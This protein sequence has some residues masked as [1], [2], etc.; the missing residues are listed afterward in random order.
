[1][2]SPPVTVFINYR[3]AE[4][5]GWARLLHDRLAAEFGKE[6]VFLDQVNLE[7]GDK[8]LHGIR[9]GSSGS[10]VFLALIGPGWA[11]RLA[12]RAESGDN[13]YVRDEIETAL[14]KGSAVREVIPALIED[15]E[16]PS[17]EDLRYVGSL[18][19]LLNHQQLELRPSRWD[20]DVE[21]LID[22]LKQPREEEEAA[23]PQPAPAEG[24]PPADP[25][26]A[27]ESV[28]PPPDQ[29]HYDE[30]AHLL[31]EEGSLVVPFLGPGANS[32][33][34]TEP[35]RDVDSAHLPDAEELA[36]Y[37]AERLGMKATPASLALVSQSLSVA[38]GPGDLYMALRRALP[39]QRQPSSVHRFLAGLPATLHGLG[40]PDRFQLI[41]TT[42]YD[43]ALEQAFDEA[44]EAYDL[45]VYLARGRD[46]GKFVHVPHDGEPQLVTDPNTYAGFPIDAFGR[47]ERTVVMKVHGAV[48][49]P[50]SP[51][52]W[53]DNY[54][55][56]EDDY[57]DYMSDGEIES[58]V[59]QQ[60][61]G[62]LR[63]YSHYLFLG[64]EMYDW[65]LR[66]FLIRV[67]GD[68]GQPNTSWA[69]E[70]EPNRLDERFWQR[71]GVDLT[72]RP[73]DAYVQEL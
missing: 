24:G 6:N 60:L 36:T 14:E 40:A 15:A 18:K 37:L 39:P 22:R 26:P 25:A 68:R 35:W 71:V 47:V 42:N 70:R 17:S 19:R 38:K 45:A 13:D 62:K 58:I 57:I 54:V 65:S 12:E 8:W 30:L 27:A 61:L 31:L 55:I 3:K 1:M 34:R 21:V 43:N 5:A 29:G 49:R 32:C 63:D 51:N 4:A 46:K 20:A 48:D 66:V 44:E 52:A 53:R 59:P 11:A 10:A 50:E 41:V 73:L 33:D 9:S 56:T 64:H 16:L 23:E 2:T 28:A 72:T 67:F 7:P 69:I